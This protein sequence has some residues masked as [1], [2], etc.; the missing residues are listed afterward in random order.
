M[1]SFLQPKI[2]KGENSRNPKT[3]EK[4]IVDEKK[5][6]LISKCRKIYLMR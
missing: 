4:V 5:K 6:I 1:G 3:G 2:K